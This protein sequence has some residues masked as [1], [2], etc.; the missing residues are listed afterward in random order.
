MEGKETGILELGK[1]LAKE[2]K[3]ELQKLEQ[4][5]AL[6]K[7]SMVG[8][9]LGGI[10]I[11]AALKYIVKSMEYKERLEV[12]M[13]MGTPH[14]GYVHSNSKLLS[15]GMWI[16]EK[17]TKN[18]IIS[19]IRLSDSTAIKDT[20]LYKLAKDKSISYFKKILLVGS[21]MDTYASFESSLVQDSDRLNGISNS[22]NIH[23]IQTKF[24]DRIEQ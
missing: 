2:I 17:F 5:G 24:L 11:R 4:L 18:S 22:E 19:Q 8:H 15:T 13:S 10:L 12:F 23:L 6:G 14:C 7:I 9:S 20:V 1:V 16:V 21:T 3:T